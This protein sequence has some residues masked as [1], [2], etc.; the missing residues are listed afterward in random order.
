MSLSALNQSAST[1]SNASGTLFCTSRA[2]IACRAASNWRRLAMPVR[3][4]CIDSACSLRLA[5]FQFAHDARQV[6]GA[7]DLRGDRVE[8]RAGIRGEEIG[9]RAFDVEHAM[10]AAAV[11]D[12]HQVF[13][14]HFAVAGQVIRVAADIA[15]QLRNAGARATP[16]RTLADRPVVG[17]LQHVEGEF[18]GPDL[19]DEMRAGLVEQDD[20]GERHRHALDQAIDDPPQHGFEV[21]A[22]VRFARDPCQQFG[23]ARAAVARVLLGPGQAGCVG[24]QVVDRRL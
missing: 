8:H 15:D 13:G 7:G 19:V 9:L 12:R 1:I 10:Q 20:A 5:G 22:F 11:A 14:T 18:A 3:P 4:S 24:A 21:F 23:Q 17:R 6:D 16:G 2:Q